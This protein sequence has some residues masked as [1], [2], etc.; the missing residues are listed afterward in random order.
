MHR[1]HRLRRMTCLLLCG[2]CLLQFTGC[3]TAAVPGFVSFLE[4]SALSLLFQS[5]LGL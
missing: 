4:S 2:G 3:L 5:V 1:T